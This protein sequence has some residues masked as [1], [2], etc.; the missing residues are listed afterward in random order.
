MRLQIHVSVM[1]SLNWV[2]TFF[3]LDE[4]AIAETIR[5]TEFG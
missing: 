1:I 3:H 5:P 2:E 4:L